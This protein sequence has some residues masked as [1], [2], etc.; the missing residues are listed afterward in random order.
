MVRSFVLTLGAYCYAAIYLPIAVNAHTFSVT[1]IDI[2]GSNQYDEYGDVLYSV[3]N[4]LIV[5]APKSSNLLGRVLLYDRKNHDADFV[6]EG[7]YFGRSVGEH[8][9]HAL[10][11]IGDALFVGAPYRTC[12]VS[13]KPYSRCGG[14]H[15]FDRSSGRNLS[16]T[17]WA[18]HTIESEIADAY[19]L[20]GTSIASS[21]SVL[22][23]GS[24]GYN[25]YLGRVSLFKIDPATNKWSLIKGLAPT[26][27]TFYGQFGYS[28]A[29]NG[30][31]LAVGSPGDTA[32]RV[33]N[34]GKNFVK[35]LCIYVGYSNRVDRVDSIYE[36]L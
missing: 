11:M 35:Y 16:K 28:L 23:V 22:A 10:A 25:G 20:F 15:V 4:K 12:Y 21:N 3:G 36:I 26:K 33:T 30:R 7:E 34:A 31:L 13:N 27:N 1:N 6:F 2:H 29:M 9:G 8:F 24:P 32:N 5:G 17:E 14:V 19:T 18:S